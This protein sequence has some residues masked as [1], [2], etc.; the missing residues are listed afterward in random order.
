MVAGMRYLI[1]SALLFAN[2]AFAQNEPPITEEDREFVYELA[3]DLA[4]CSGFYEA[5]S[6][7]YRDSNEAASKNFGNLSNGAEIASAWAAHAVTDW[8][9]ALSFAKNLMD[10]E[11]TSWLFTLREGK[12]LEDIKEQS[13]ECKQI[14]PL[15]V[16]FV[17]EVRK[18]VYG[19]KE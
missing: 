14:Y 17:E 2:T 16:Q 13:E 18:K 12:A 10:A 8:K 1:V 9:N 15:Q 6:I 4:S 3:R 7:A 11:T 19:F 5:L